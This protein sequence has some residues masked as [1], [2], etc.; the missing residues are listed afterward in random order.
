[1]EMEHMMQ[2]LADGLTSVTEVN[3]LAETHR[4][5]SEMLLSQWNSQ[6][7]VL[8]EAH[9]E[10]FRNWLMSLYHKSVQSGDLSVEDFGAFGLFAG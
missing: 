1:M 5:D 9:R 8:H 7:Q 6:I 2:K 10:E 4:Y 3:T